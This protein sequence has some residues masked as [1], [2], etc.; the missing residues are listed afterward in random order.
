VAVG[1]ASACDRLRSECAALWRALHDHPFIRELAAGTLPP[2][3]FRFYVEQNLMYLPEYARAMAIAASKAEDLETM[4]V[5]AGDLQNILE[6]EIPENRELLRRTLELGAPDRG[7]ALCMAPANV[8]YT[9]FLVA[10][11]IQGDSLDV[12][13]AIVPCTW[14]YG[15]IA[16]T[17]VAE[18]LVHDHPVYAE[19]IRFFG[20]PAYEAI[21]ARMR[22]DF[23]TMA[24]TADEA[25]LQHLSA[26]FKTSV[27]LER[28]FWE[29]A[30]GLEQWPDVRAQRPLT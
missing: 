3:K 2:E 16:S 14:S 25:T 9:G 20:L 7:G 29:G 5:F 8:A 24:A 28:A 4:L 19:W 12:M 18:G 13:A 23:D 22:S 15:D 11:A 26:L 30:Y 6:S 10:T 21:V 17:L 1:A 27:R